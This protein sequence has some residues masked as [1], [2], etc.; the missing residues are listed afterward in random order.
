MSK[1]HVVFRPHQSA[2]RGQNRNLSTA[3]PL[4][5]K[6]GRGFGGDALLLFASHDIY[7]AVFY[8]T[9][10]GNFGKPSGKLRENRPISLPISH[11]FSSY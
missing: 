2:V 1:P 6:T 3:A 7:F 9:T 10:K 5:S 8:S 11:P 4:V